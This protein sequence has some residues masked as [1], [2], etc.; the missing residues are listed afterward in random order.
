MARQKTYVPITRADLISLVPATL[1]VAVKESKKTGKKVRRFTIVD[2]K[3]ALDVISALP[4]DAVNR[5]FMDGLNREIYFNSGSGAKA[6]LEKQIAKLQATLAMKSELA[7]KA[8]Q[9]TE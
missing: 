8:S 6:R 3:S 5:I 4:A 2:G 9:D 7:S 1:A